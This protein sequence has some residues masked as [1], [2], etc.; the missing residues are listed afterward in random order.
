TT[1]DLTGTTI[2]NSLHPFA[3]WIAQNTIAPCSRADSAKINQGNG[4][5]GQLTPDDIILF[6][7]RYFASDWRAD[8][9]GPNQS[10][11]PDEQFSA[12]DLIVFFA[13]FFQGC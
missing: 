6:L 11:G 12:D 7:T 10:I 8:I 2:V 4:P 1:S 9:A 3:A 5:D 13:W